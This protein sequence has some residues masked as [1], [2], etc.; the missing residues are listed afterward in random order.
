MAEKHKS[1]GSDV[2]SK[3]CRT[4][5][6]ETKKEIIKG[7]EKGGTPTEMGRDLD[8]P[9]TAIMTIPKD[10][11]RIQEHVKDSAPMHST[12][13]TEQCVGLIAEVEKLLII[14]LDDQNKHRPPVSLGIIQEKAR[15]LYD[16]LK[17]QQGESS[18]AE[19]FT[20]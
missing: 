2:S 13:I 7:S 10:K 5:T 15:T 11:A 19:P 16:D 4:I 18:N 20:A 9:R 1:G 8:I 14:W 3:K 12:V 17:K 6:M